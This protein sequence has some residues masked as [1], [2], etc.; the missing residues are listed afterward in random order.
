MRGWER[1]RVLCLHDDQSKPGRALY[2][3]DE[4]VLEGRV[5]EHK[6]YVVKGFT[7]KLQARS[8]RLLRAIFRR[9]IAIT[10][11]K[12]IKGWRR[13]KKNELVRKLNPKWE[14]PRA[15]IIWRKCLTA[16]LVIPNR[17]DG[18]GPH[19]GLGERKLSC[20]IQHLRRGPSLALGMTS[21]RW[22]ARVARSRNDYFPRKARISAA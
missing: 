12:E 18:E 5:W 8:P 20:V 2:R 7:S 11:E 3:R 16:P 21:M 13:K 4:Q 1:E 9:D 6:N 22:R 14:D 19:Q 10:R 17:T 15:K